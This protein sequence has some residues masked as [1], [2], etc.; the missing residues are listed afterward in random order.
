MNDETAKR[1]GSL[2]VGDAQRDAIHVAVAPV[3]AGCLLHPGERVGM[4]GGK[5]N[6]ATGEHVGIVDPFLRGPVSR[7]ERL[8]L[9]LFPGSITSL[10]HEWVHPLMDAAATKPDRKAE[11]ELWMT[12]WAKEHMGTDYYGPDDADGNPR[13][14]TG[15]EAL[16][17]AVEAGRELHIGPYE[18]AREHINNEWWDHWVNITGEK[19]Q[20]DEFFSCSC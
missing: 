1:I 4:V 10:R 18:S 19:A 20:R 5:A 12:A 8:W 14:W 13:K 2:I 7:G 11:S 3:F 15:P 16:A 17:K 6:N 9:F